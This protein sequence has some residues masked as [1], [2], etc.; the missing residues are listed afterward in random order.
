MRGQV[1]PQSH[2]FS[3]FSPER[4]RKAQMAL[5]SVR[6]NRPFCEALTTTSCFAGFWT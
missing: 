3:Y 2:W 1:D 6:S 5:Y 4:L